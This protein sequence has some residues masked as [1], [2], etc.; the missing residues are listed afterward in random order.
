MMTKDSYLDFERSLFR[1]E[2]FKPEVSAGSSTIGSTRVSC[3][4]PMAYH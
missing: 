4:S 2:H 3:D 1:T